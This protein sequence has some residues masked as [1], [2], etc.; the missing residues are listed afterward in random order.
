M[1]QRAME[2]SLLNIKLRHKQRNTLIRNKTQVIDALQHAQAL[3]W[4]WAGHLMR[5]SDDRWTRTTTL[6]KG[7]SGK[8][9]RGRP[10]ERWQDEIVEIAGKAW[11][12]LATEKKQWKLLEE[13]Y[14]RRGAL[15]L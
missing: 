14:T 7:P 2:R 15:N 3:K 12:Q 4:R 1:C 11:K 9:K 5:T 10:Q 13:A 8:R 6:W